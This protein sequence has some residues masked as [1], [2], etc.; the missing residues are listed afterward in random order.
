[1][2]NFNDEYYIAF[3]PSGDNQIYIKPDLKT[4]M[5]KY[6]FK[7]LNYGEAPLIFLNGFRDEDN[8]KWPVTDLFVDTSGVLINDSLRVELN[9]YD[10]SYMQIYPSIYID[11]KDN[12]HDNT[13][14]YLGFYDEISCLDVEKSKIETFDFGD[15]EEEDELHEVKKYHLSS[16]ILSNFDEEARLIFKMGGCSKNYLFFHKKIVRFINSKKLSGIKFIKVSDFH[17]GDQF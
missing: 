13:Y 2:N 5:R 4:A 3:R 9:K 10:I 1:M 12:H 6:H 11:D 7:K 15:D 16:D 8:N 17:E 14:W